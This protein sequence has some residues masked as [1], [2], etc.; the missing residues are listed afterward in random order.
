MSFRNTLIVLGVL[1]SP[2]ATAA[3]TETVAVLDTELIIDNKPGPHAP[4]R[5]GEIERGGYMTEHIRMALDNS[6]VYELVNLD[7]ARDTVEVQTSAVKYVHQ[8]QACV[9]DIGQ[10]LEV[11]YVATVWVQVVSNLIINFNLVFRD[12]ET[13]E[14]ARTTFIDI[15]GNNNSSWRTGTNYLLEKHFDEYFDEI[16]EQALEE[17]MTVWPES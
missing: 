14:V 12:A 7:A 3:N 17:A 4:D 2:L 11:D 9:R 10:A 5:P 6:D 16:P 15:R 1:F 8:C 13:G